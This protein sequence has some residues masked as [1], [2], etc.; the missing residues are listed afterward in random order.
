MTWMHSSRFAF[1]EMDVVF[2][3]EEP[4]ISVVFGSF[5][6]WLDFFEDGSWGS[7]EDFW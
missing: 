3:G 4:G 7:G 1:S 6:F 5:F 2:D